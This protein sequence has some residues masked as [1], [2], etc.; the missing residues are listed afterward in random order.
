MGGASDGVD[1]ALCNL[2]RTI[3]GDVSQ[4]LMFYHGNYVALSEEYSHCVVE[5]GWVI[6]TLVIVNVCKRD[7]VFLG[8]VIKLNYS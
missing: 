8:L 6:N 5:R 7:R 3:D 1:N 2:E 4:D